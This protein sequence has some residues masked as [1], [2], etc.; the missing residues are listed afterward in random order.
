MSNIST[1]CG[2]WCI[3]IVPI[4]GLL[5]L[6]VAGCRSPSIAVSLLVKKGTF[7]CDIK[8][9]CMTSLTYEFHLDKVKMTDHDKFCFIWHHSEEKTSKLNGC[10]VWNA[11]S[12]ARLSVHK[13]LL[14]HSTRPSVTWLNSW[15]WLVACDWVM[16]ALSAVFSTSV[17]HRRKFGKVSCTKCTGQ[18]NDFKLIPTV[19][20]ETRNPV[21]DYFG[22]EFPAICNH[23]GVYG[24]LKSQ[25][26][27]F[28][29][30]LRFGGKR[31]ITVKFAKLCCESFYRESDRRVV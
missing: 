22:S 24:S 18:G 10:I 5:F 9:W 15:W 20:M 13:L 8:L 30:I 29:K 12:T 31:L 23:C 26:V 3:L 19:N 11:H 17:G 27:N 7:S 6:Y 21:E 14:L 4:S 16:S 28:F 1:T 2:W 25:D